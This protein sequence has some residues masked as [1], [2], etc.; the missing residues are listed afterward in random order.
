M[1]EGE[2]VGLWSLS[3]SKRTSV[4]ASGRFLPAQQCPPKPTVPRAW[5]PRYPPK[6]SLG[7]AA[8]QARGRNAG[9]VDSRGQW[10]PAMTQSRPSSGA[11]HPARLC[12]R[13]PP[14]PAACLLPLCLP[15][16]IGVTASTSC[17]IYRQRGAGRERGAGCGV[18]ERRGAARRGEGPAPLHRHSPGSAFHTSPRAPTKAGQARWDT[19]LRQGR[20][21][22]EEKGCEHLPLPTP[23][24]L[25]VKVKNPAQGLKKGKRTQTG[26]CCGRGPGQNLIL[27]NPLNGPVRKV[28]VS[29]FTDGKNEAQRYSAEVIQIIQ[30]KCVP[31]I[32]G[33]TEAQVD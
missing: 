5:G 18:P 7:P 19:T 17:A 2:K 33:E 22:D 23:G 29:L 31:F 15:G 12:A 8:P 13:R 32:H 21:A 9:G 1:L 4:P 10:G 27:F 3:G 25:V 20:R 24:T 26:T 30:P 16:H 28:L 14:A 6:A 11:W